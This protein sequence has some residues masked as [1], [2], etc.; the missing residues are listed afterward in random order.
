[1]NAIF[2]YAPQLAEQIASRWSEFAYRVVMI[3]PWLRETCRLPPEAIL[4]HICE[5]A[6]QISLTTEEARSVHAKLIWCERTRLS[7][8]QETL[9]IVC[10]PIVPC[11]IATVSELNRLAPA[12]NPRHTAIVLSDGPSDAVGIWGLVHFGS[13]WAQFRAGELAPNQIPRRPPAYL[14]FDVRGPGHIGVS[15][16][17]RALCILR[18]GETRFHPVDILSEASSP[19]AD[20][21]ASARFRYVDQARDAGHKTALDFDFILRGAY[22]AYLMRLLKGAAER[23]HGGA[24][25]FVRD[26]T[27]DETQLPQLRVKYPLKVDVV[28]K[29]LID[30]F[31]DQGGER[32]GAIGRLNDAADL[33]INLSYVDGA[34][35]LTDTFRV[36]G[37]GAEIIVDEGPRSVSVFDG[38][39]GTAKGDIPI[40]A[41]G[42]RH[43]S[44][45]RLCTAM[46]DVVAFVVSQDG[47]VRGVMA[48]AQGGVGLWPDVAL[49]HRVA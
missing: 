13:L 29:A 4:S 33:V 36:I 10:A 22:D 1:M 43:R 6:Y 19:L 28:W 2:T 25:V 48:L 26:A 23:R 3:S 49:G 5:L 30:A 31:S 46:Q 34:V 12:T 7:E 39:R 38:G 44:A 9:D 45:F 16:A 40:D 21:F 17:G 8:L 11:R 20:W 15:F 14:T 35:V 42:T 41:F 24:F 37:F 18:D 27:R 47:D 32:R